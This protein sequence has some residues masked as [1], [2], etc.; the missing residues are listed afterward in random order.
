MHYRVDE[1][2]S[3]EAP[4]TSYWGYCDGR[5]IYIRYG[6]DF[7]QLERRDAAFYIASTL[8]AKRRNMN[9]AG[10]NFLIGLTALSTSIAAKDGVNFHGFSAIPIPEIPM[11]VLSL[12]PGANILGLH[13]DLDTGQ[14]TY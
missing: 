2:I 10:W 9:K 12:D 14:I 5:N 13:V 4:D 7:Y 11:I 3:N 1:E 8:D 6:Y